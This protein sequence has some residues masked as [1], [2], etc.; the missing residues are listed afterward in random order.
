MPG[1]DVKNV[2]AIRSLLIA[3]SFLPH[4]GGSRVYYYHLYR[5][6]APDR[7]TVLTKEIPG[8]QEFDRRESNE[9]FKIVRRFKP[10]RTTKYGEL[11]KAV[12]PLV[13]AFVRAMFWP[14]DVVVCGDLFPPGPIAVLLKRAF[15]LPYIVHCHGDDLLQAGRYRRQLRVRNGIYRAADMVIANSEFTR[16]L[17]L[18]IG[19]PAQRIRKITPGVDCREFAPAATDQD[20]V[21]RFGLQGALVLLTVARLVPRKGHDMVLRAVAKLGREFPALRYLITGCGPE[22]TK[23]RQLA[24]DLGISER[25]TFVGYVPQEK[26]PDYYR[27]SHVMVMPNR[28]EAGD[29]EGFGMAFLEASAAGKPVIAGMSGGAS[30]AVSDGVTGLLIEPTDLDQLAAAIRTLLL[31][32]RMAE[33][34]GAA[35]LQRARAE[36]DWKLRSAELR[37]ITRAVVARGRKWAV[38]RN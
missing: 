21:A 23:L 15:G 25:V 18:E 14:V 22:E 7:V 9:H 1:A 2:R 26:L 36:F 24:A 17:L 32:P 16:Q 4:A 27:L 10:L 35:G 28:E 20:L 30:E 33:E 31:Q 38:S 19:I 37:E 5:D 12:L 6:W 11:P 3:D 8:W 13:H 34:M 29:K